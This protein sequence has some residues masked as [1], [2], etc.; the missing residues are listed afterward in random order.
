MPRRTHALRRPLD[1]HAGDD[2]G[3]IGEMQHRDPGGPCHQ[4]TAQEATV[5]SRKNRRSEPDEGIGDSADEG[6]GVETLL[7]EAE[8]ALIDRHSMEGGGHDDQ[9]ERGENSS[10]DAIR[11]QGTAVIRPKPAPDEERQRQHQRRDG[12]QLEEPSARV[13]REAEPG[14]LTDQ[15]LPAE[16]VPP[17]QDD[18]G[19]KH[20]VNY[21]KDDAHLDC[22][23]A[24][25][26]PWKGDG[27]ASPP[28]EHTG[29]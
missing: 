17:L 20:H 14:I 15:R 5:A 28:A 22:P 21:A 18:E 25:R 4:R 12:Y 13:L 11:A 27:C 2:G 29:G 7:G 1:I 8:L 6:A 9:S 26:S 23:E 10:R 16:E 24:S 19:Q 3:G